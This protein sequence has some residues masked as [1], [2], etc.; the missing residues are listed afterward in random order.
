MNNNTKDSWQL[1]L[2]KVVFL[3]IVGML[4]RDMIVMLFADLYESV[5]SGWQP[6]AA[7]SSVI[8]LT[9]IITWF[10]ATKKFEGKNHSQKKPDNKPNA[11]TTNFQPNNQNRR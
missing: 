4:I 11:P 8:A 2:L 3:L 6:A 9:T 7:S 5:T 1:V 10:L